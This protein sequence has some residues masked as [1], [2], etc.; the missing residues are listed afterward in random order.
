MSELQAG[1]KHVYGVECSG[2]IHSARQV[3][4]TPRSHVLDGARSCTRGAAY[5]D[6][7]EAALAFTWSRAVAASCHVSPSAR[8]RRPALLSTLSFLRLSQTPLLK[9]AF[10]LSRT[11]F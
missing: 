8:S 11:V 10:C 1:A 3:L 6:W 7:S 4:A 2:I 5:A 9:F